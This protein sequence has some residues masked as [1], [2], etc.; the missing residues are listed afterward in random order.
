MITEYDY[1]PNG[2]LKTETFKTL[3]TYKSQTKTES[4]D[5]YDENGLL[6][7]EESWD[8]LN[9]EHDVYEYRYQFF[10]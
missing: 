7:K 10:E 5:I 3:D 8:Y 2:Q 6:L 4:I 1:H 9:D